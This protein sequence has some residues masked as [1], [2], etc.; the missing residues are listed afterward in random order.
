MTTRIA[1]FLITAALFAGGC[2]SAPV[3]ARTEKT[4]PVREYAREKEKL[5]KTDVVSPGFT[6]RIH[7]SADE[8][9]SGEFKVNFKGQLKLPYNITV[10]AGGVTTDELAEK[11]AKSYS[12]YFKV[13][14]TVTVEIAR[15]EYLIEIRGLVQKPAVY[16]VKLDTSIEEVIAM[17]G[18]LQGSAGVG[19]GKGAAP[20][21]KPEYIRIVRPDFMNPSGESSV[22]WVR[23][24]D[25]FLKYDVRNEV[26][27][28]GGE[29][30]FFQMTGDPD[31]V[32]Q[33]KSE[34]I[35]V[36]GEVHKPGEYP[37][38]PGADLLNYIAGAGG[39]TSTADL[40]NVVVMLKEEDDSDTHD[41]SKSTKIVDL[42]PGD[43]ILVKS[44]VTKPSSFERFGP[45]F[46][47][48]GSLVV[49]V[50]L[51]LFAI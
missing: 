4:D 23:L 10:K 27:W 36:I 39:P 43:V 45:V 5:E 9:I 6:L 3:R 42:A 41:V 49:S 21:S 31:A 50:L 13:K 14:N 7:H 22:H 40:S 48:L 35:Q 24:T 17:S 30:L 11:L 8:E 38:R 16:A 26:L 37:V 51:V 33:A 25:Y 29:E 12:P 15:R 34:T 47:S 2:S 20:S 28:R 1:C 32:R 19:D 44:T 46:I 18:G